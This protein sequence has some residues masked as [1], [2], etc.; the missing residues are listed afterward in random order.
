MELLS[1]R[2]ISLN[3]WALCFMNE[4]KGLVIFRFLAHTVKLLYRKVLCVC[5]C[6]FFLV[7]FLT[8]FHRQWL[9]LRG[10]FH[11][12]PTGVAY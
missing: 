5:V 11:L 8:T 12:A 9:K 7:F 3:V 1:C 2:V 10:K 6:V 4:S